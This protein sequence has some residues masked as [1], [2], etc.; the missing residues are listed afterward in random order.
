M[1]RTLLFVSLLISSLPAVVEANENCSQCCCTQCRKVCRVVCEMKKE[2]VFCYECECEDFCIPGRS[3]I[4]GVKCVPNVCNPC[5]THREYC[6]QP[7]CGPIKQRKIL[8]KVAKT[9]EKPVYRCVVERV[10]CQCG[11]AK[12]DAA[13]TS[14]LVNDGN[15]EGIEFDRSTAVLPVN[16]EVAETIID[17]ED[18]PAKIKQVTFLQKIFR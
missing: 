17:G 9:I 10:C 3:C 2:T 14:A 13:A 18:E 7:H 15:I 11:L 6:W 5:E 12:S 4:T 8:H 16:T 1:S